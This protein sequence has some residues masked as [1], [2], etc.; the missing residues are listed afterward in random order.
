MPDM[1]S[2]NDF[3]SGIELGTI[4][5]LQPNMLLGITVKNLRYIFSRGAISLTKN[6]SLTTMKSELKTK[7]LL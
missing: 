5:M 4:T 6:N 7:S 3:I 1:K 2:L